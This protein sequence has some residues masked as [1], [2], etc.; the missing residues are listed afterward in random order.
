MR[1]CV[2]LIK[3]FLFILNFLCF[4]SFCALFGGTIYVLLY[5]ED[6]FIGQ[7]IEPSLD[8]TDSTNATYF[9]FIVIALVISGFLALFTCLGCCGAAT[10]SGCMLGSFIVILFVLFGGSVGAV[11]FL[12]TQFGWQAV[13]EVLNQELNRNLQLYKED[14]ILTYKFWNWLQPTFRCCGVQDDTSFIVWQDVAPNVHGNWKVPE[15]CCTTDEECM[16]EP[17]RDNTYDQGCAP[18][19]LLYAQILFYG[20]P[21][22]ML[23]SLVFAF[24]V[25]SSNSSA[26]RRR[27][28]TRSREPPYNSQYSIG[29]DEDFSRHQSNYPNPTAPAHYSDNPPFNPGYDTELSPYYGGNMMDY[30]TGT[31]PPPHSHVPL[32]HQAPPSYNDVVSRR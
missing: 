24:I 7:K 21:S 4:L 30:P 2:D 13:E 27:K 5:G 12:H 9:L 10:K 20:I 23:V 29:A 8:K 28:A 15:S 32:L 22:L 11:I 31:V 3:F 6:T 25:S 17:N 18:K 19:I 14:N 26:V 1:C 16:Y